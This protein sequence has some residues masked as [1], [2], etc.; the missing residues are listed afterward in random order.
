MKLGSPKGFTLVEVMIVITII[1]IIAAI[2][3]PNF[4]A[5][6]ENNRLR[7][8]SQDLLSN[9]QYAKFEAIKRNRNVIAVFA[10][11][12]CAPA[13]PDPGGNYTIFVDDGSGGGTSGD[14]IRQAN[15]PILRQEAMR[16]GIGL[17]VGSVAFNNALL[18]ANTYGFTP[19]GRPVGLN[20]GTAG[21][22]NGTGRVHTLT[23][24]VAGNL[25]L[26]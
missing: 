6:L 4:L 23:L 10:P 25:S 22:R 7:D 16:S 12:A 24:G 13:I 18:P 1:G 19:T 9:L 20:S 14:S 3:T 21:L 8:A 17:C 26:N 11:V 15:E 5:W 2:A